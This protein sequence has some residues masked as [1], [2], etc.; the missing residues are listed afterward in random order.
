MSE[1]LGDVFKKWVEGSADSAELCTRLKFFAV[2]CN[3]E[4]PQKNEIKVQRMVAGR[5][6]AT[7]LQEG[8]IP[9][10][11]SGGHHSIKDV[12]GKI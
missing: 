7:F 12:W 11:I 1:I 6:N 3:C 9:L 8:S 2:P 5:N 4:D 10:G